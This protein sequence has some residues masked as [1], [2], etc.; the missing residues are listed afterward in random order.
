[1]S[2]TLT[3]YFVS[4]T[5]HVLGAVGRIAD[6]TQESPQ[7]T[8]SLESVL[9]RGLEQEPATEILV[10]AAELSTLVLPPNPDLLLNP[11]AFQ[12]PA[13]GNGVQLLNEDLVVSGITLSDRKVTVAL[14]ADLTQA[15]AVWVLITGGAL[16]VPLVANGTI[17]AGK[18]SIDLTIG[19]LAPGT[20]QSLVLVREHQPFVQT[21]TIQS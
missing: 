6:A 21:D 7:Q 1:M 13:R 4:K 12:V 10:P 3:V 19:P 15:E 17:P 14:G 9:V 5:G 8:P 20:Y 18:F 16:K 11:L 2:E